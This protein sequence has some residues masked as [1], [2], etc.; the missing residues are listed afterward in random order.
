MIRRDFYGKKRGNGEGTIYYNKNL[1]KWVGQCTAG[2]KE[3]GDPIRVTVY[4][5]TRKENLTK[6][7]IIEIINEIFS[8][9]EKVPNVVLLN[10]L[11]SVL[12]TQEMPME[13]VETLL[14]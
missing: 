6:N 13:N 2:Y 5:K 3:N 7:D 1:K 10:S 4:G 9:L 14:N 8:N 12:D 11:G